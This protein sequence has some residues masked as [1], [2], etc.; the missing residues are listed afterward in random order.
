MKIIIPAYSNGDSGRGALL[1]SLHMY[2]GASGGEKERERGVS[3]CGTCPWA[4]GSV[5]ARDEL[6]IQPLI[7]LSLESPP[8]SARRCAIR[9]ACR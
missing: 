5:A 3:V 7:K 4:A 2:R 9:C 8:S 6:N 1:R